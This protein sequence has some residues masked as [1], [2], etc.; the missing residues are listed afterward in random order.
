MKSRKKSARPIALT[1][2]AAC[3]F[4]VMIA[5]A[6]V[7]LE[8]KVAVEGAGMMAMVNMSGTT[9][10]AI[11]GNRARLDNNIQMQSKLV[12]MFAKDAGETTEIIRL[13]QDKIYDINVKKKQYSEVS[14]AAKRAE[15]TKALDQAKQAQ[16]KQPPPTGMDE[17]ECEWSD[18]KVEVKK[19]GAKATIAG[20]DAEQTTIVAT[21]SCKDKKSSAVCDVQISLDEWLA[22]GFDAGAEH[23]KFY[24]MYAEKMGLT[25]TGSR[26]VTQRAEQLFGRY[27]GIWGEV[28]AKMKNVKGYP[29]RSSFAMGFG[30]PQCKSAEGTPATLPPQPTLG[31]DIGNAAAEG[32]GEAVAQAAATKAGQG[33]LGGVAGQ[34]GGKIAGA[35]FNR[36]KKTADEPQAAQPPAQTAP[37]TGVT[38]NNMIVPLRVTSELIS[39]KKDSVA[40]GTFEVPTGFKKVAEGG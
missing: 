24:Q 38:A 22:P 29:V 9:T 18:P 11:S 31:A 34:I 13:D 17:S 28:A 5:Y 16:A 14:L 33:G 3:L 35:L 32:A 1:T 20:F 23:Q 10:T 12:R 15:M 19:T 27:K 4:A 30:G 37:A 2:G 26:D 7:T 39:V 25:G 8:E 40:A 6:D 21:Q 36:H